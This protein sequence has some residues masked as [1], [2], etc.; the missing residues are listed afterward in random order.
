MSNTGFAVGLVLGVFV[1]ASFATGLMFLI[2]KIFFSVPE[3]QQNFTK[4][5]AD[6]QK[7][8]QRQE[9]EAKP[10]PPKVAPAL[11]EPPINKEQAENELVTTTN[12]C[13]ENEKN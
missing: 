6:I 11:A 10:Q 5:Q 13:L 9:E 3:T 7:L 1:G 4:L 2:K 12:L 8:Y